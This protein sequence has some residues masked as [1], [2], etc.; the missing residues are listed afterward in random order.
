MSNTKMRLILM[1]FLE[2]FVWG[3][4]MM[5]LGT[6]AFGVKHWDSAEFGIIFAT[7]GI[8]W[9]YRRQVDK[10][11]CFVWLAAFTIWSYALHIADDK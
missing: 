7:M 3:A 1:N 5:T 8:I 10:I 6:Y 9:Y 4:W 11:K 2:F